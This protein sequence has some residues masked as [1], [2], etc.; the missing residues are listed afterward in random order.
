MKKLRLLG[1][2]AATLLATA[3]QA[4]VLSLSPATV[5]AAPGQT[6]GWG[7][8]LLNDDTANFLLVT[9]TEFSL[10]P[11]S[12]FGSYADLLASPPSFVVLAP[13][14]H[15]SESYDAT[16]GT[17]IGQFSLAP[18]AQGSLSGQIQLHYALFSVDPNSA[19][20][21]PDLHLVNP[22]ATA[23]ASAS[24]GAVPE[25]STWSLFGAAGLLVAA[26][27]RRALSRSTA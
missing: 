8:S 12:A 20:F 27:R 5:N 13:L 4:A 25:P 3:A 15:L 11:P 10:A 7:F 26:W 6:T 2:A 1:V 24:V 23:F 17:G 22:D 9:G 18:S 16:L 14:A 19:G 21:D